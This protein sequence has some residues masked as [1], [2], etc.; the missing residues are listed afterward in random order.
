MHG[1]HDSINALNVYRITM[2][3]QSAEGTEARDGFL[4]G[5]CTRFTIV[6]VF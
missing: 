4:T 2:C 6:A 5:L 1:T 3:S